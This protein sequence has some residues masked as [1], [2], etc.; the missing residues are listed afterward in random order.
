MGAS[1]GL[2]V[3]AHDV[4]HSDLGDRL[5]D[6]VDLGADQVLVG[7]G[8]GPGQKRH[9]DGTVGRDLGV[10]QLG[11]PLSE[12]LG[13]R[14]ELEVHPGRQRLHVAAGHRLA[15]FVPDHAAEDV[16]RGVGAHQGVAPLPVERA[17]DPGPHLGG[18]AGDGVPHHVVAPHVGDGGR[19]AVPLQC[20]GVVGLPAPGG[21]EGGGVER[22]PALVVHRHHRGAERPQLGVPQI[23]TVSGHSGLLSCPTHSRPGLSAAHVRLSQALPSV[24]A[25]VRHLRSCRL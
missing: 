18:A 25:H 3:E 21:V 14:P 16:Q 11:H 7:Q 12:P 15:P 8:L 20:A 13:Q 9:L 6:E 19:P 24:Q 4:H 5:G 10:D 23:Q 1:V 22:H 2:L 17:G